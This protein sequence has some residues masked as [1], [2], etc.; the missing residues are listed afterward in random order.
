MKFD[1]M[2]ARSKMASKTYV[3]HFLLSFVK[4][5]N[6]W[7]KFLGAWLSLGYQQICI[8][9]LFLRSPLS[10]VSDEILQDFF[11]K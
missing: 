1:K 11:Y 5:H 10:G 3:S 4:L 9:K 6:L 2:A 8:K 7:L